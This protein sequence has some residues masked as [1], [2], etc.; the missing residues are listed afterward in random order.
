MAPCKLHNGVLSQFLLFHWRV[1]EIK[2]IL[3]ILMLCA[4]SCIQISSYG[5]RM[6]K[7]LIR[8]SIRNL[9][10]FR[11]V[12]LKWLRA[13]WSIRW[14]RTHARKTPQPQDSCMM[15]STNSHY[16]HC[17]HSHQ[18]TIFCISLQPMRI[19]GRERQE[20]TEECMHMGLH[21]LY[22]SPKIIRLNGWS[23]TWW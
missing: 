18:H 22:T 7:N 5:F 9:E 15:T 14:H 11:D 23:K 19:P 8:W 13:R 6:M 4:A 17:P 10:Q 12:R 16:V 1:L 21:K 20:G 3:N 2:K